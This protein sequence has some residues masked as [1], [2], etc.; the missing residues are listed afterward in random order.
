MGDSLG[1]I[2]ANR[3]CF[4]SERVHKMGMSLFALSS[5]T[6]CNPQLPFLTLLTEVE[7]FRETF[8]YILNR[9]ASNTI[10][11]AIGFYMCLESSD[12][13]SHCETV[14]RILFDCIHRC[15]S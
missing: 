12:S 3:R 1:E 14:I 5:Y 11:N 7:Y 10:R 13:V 9:V 15:Y 8:S 6:D 2:E 4:S